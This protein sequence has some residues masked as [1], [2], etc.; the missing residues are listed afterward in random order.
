MSGYRG[1]L[2]E[3]SRTGSLRSMVLQVQTGVVHAVGRWLG[4]SEADPVARFYEN[5]GPDGVRPPDP[6][7]RALDA[8]A[9]ECLVCGLCSIACAQVGGTPPRDPRDAVV[10]A[11]RLWADW[12]RLDLA[13]VGADPCSGCDAC[14]RSCPAGIPI[15]RVQQHL[16]V[17]EGPTPRDATPRRI[18]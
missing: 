18:G 4:R 12:Q 13:P 6:A 11:A 5:Y 1:F 9:Q 2:R 15:H 3:F 8:Q 16:P 17:R 10:A 7:R 14:S